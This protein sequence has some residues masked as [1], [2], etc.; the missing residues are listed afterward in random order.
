MSAAHEKLVKMSQNEE[1]EDD[2]LQ[3]IKGAVFLATV[4]SL[5]LIAGFGSTLALSRKNN[6][7]SFN[8][9]VMATAALPESGVALALR[10]LG[11]GSAYAFC[12]VGLLSLAAWKLLGVGSLSDF[13]HKMASLFPPIPKSDAAAGSDP[14]DLDSLFKSK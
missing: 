5:G 4:S 7:D 9:G 13:R 11:R 2:K 3:L 10:A 6:P 14:H 1:E 12:G 8:K